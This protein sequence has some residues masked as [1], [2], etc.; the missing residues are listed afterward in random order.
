LQIITVKPQIKPSRLEQGRTSQEEAGEPRRSKPG[1]KRSKTQTLEIHHTEIVKTEEVPART[2]SV[3]S[4][5]M[6]GVRWLHLG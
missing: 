3:S 6:A 1:P 2:C 5:A 4:A